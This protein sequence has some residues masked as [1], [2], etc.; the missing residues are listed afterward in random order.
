MQILPELHA[1]EFLISTVSAWITFNHRIYI[2]KP[3]NILA[4]LSSA[5]AYSLPVLFSENILSDEDFLTG[6]TSGQDVAIME[7]T[8]KFFTK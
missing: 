2:Y 7:C 6:G 1:V 8:A 5:Y 3:R 4:Y